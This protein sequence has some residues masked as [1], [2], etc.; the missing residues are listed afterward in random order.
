MS[1]MHQSP[2]PGSSWT[3]SSP[4]QGVEDRRPKLFWRL[5][6][7]FL[8]V[9]LIWPL[10]QYVANILFGPDYSRP[11]HILRAVLASA[12]TLPTIVL[13]RRVL[14]QRPWGGLALGSLHTGWR[15]LLLG[16]FCWL[17]PAGVGVAI[18]VG[19]G[20]TEITLNAPLGE[21]LLLGA[22]LLLLVFLF[23]ALPE[24]LVFRGY[25]YRNLAAALPRWL[26]VLAQAGLFMLWGIINGGENSAE[27]SIMFFCVAVVL[28]IFRVVTGSVW[29][30][31]GFHLAFQ[32]VAQLFGSIGGVFTIGALPTLQLF[33]FGIFPAALSVLLLGALVRGRPSWAEREPEP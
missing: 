16:M 25:I 29:A 9:A 12:L 22:G 10:L 32:T 18:C 1:D 4:H 24:E 31:I 8:A 23:E 17:V 3:A 5:A 30:S 26:A 11:G 14:D 15:P 2:L 20:W 28:G 27:R 33:A 7:V 19:L 13:A 6:I 21:T